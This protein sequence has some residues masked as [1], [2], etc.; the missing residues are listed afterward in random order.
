MDLETGLAQAWRRCVEN[1]PESR[2]LNELA[3]KVMPGGNIR[4]VLFF[5]SFPLTFVRGDGARVWDAD[6]HKYINMIAGMRYGLYRHANATIAAAI[7]E[8][9]RDGLSLSAKNK[10]DPTA[11][12]RDSFPHPSIDL[13]RFANSCNEA[14][15][16]AIEAARVFTDKST[17]LVFN[18]AYHGSV[19]MFP[20][21]SQSVNVP[22]EFLVVPYNDSEAARTLIARHAL[23]NAEVVVEPLQ[24]VAGRIPADTKFLAQ[25][26]RSASDVGAV[27]IF[28][29]VIASRLELGEL[30]SHY[31]VIPDLTGLGKYLSGGLSFGALGGKQEIMQLF[32][33]RRPRSLLRAGWRQRKH[34]A[35]PSRSTPSTVQ[36][37]WR[38]ERRRHSSGSAFSTRM[39]CSRA[40]ATLVTSWVLNPRID[41]VEIMCSTKGSSARLRSKVFRG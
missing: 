4:S 39:C 10:Y 21:G 28:D 36:R 17:L 13:V 19:P 20:P 40:P 18:G 34:M 26:R 6:G 32:D 12:S 2:R 3:C 23:E 38:A 30:Q 33:Q 8:G 41:A 37:Y 14:N 9:L 35:C 25:L 24:D 7:E 5:D 27:L 31:G 1:H 15:P 29:E 16:L 22:Y 11:G